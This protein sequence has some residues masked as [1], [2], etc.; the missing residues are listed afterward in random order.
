MLTIVRTAKLLTRR[1]ICILAVIVTL[2]AAE[3]AKAQEGGLIERQTT[4]EGRLER[5]EQLLE[6]NLRP[7]KPVA[8]NVMEFHNWV[9]DKDHNRELEYE[10]GVIRNNGFRLVHVSN[11]NGGRRYMTEPYWRGDEITDDDFGLGGSF[12]LIGTEEPKEQDCRNK[13]GT[14]LHYYYLY[15]AN[16]VRQYGGNGCK[17]EGTFYARKRIFIDDI[18]PGTGFPNAAD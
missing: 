6:L 8:A 18:P 11:W 15:G 16:G 14:A 7:W 3:G 5:I 17:P 2:F 13:P 4:L 10:F 12:W 9:Q 1:V